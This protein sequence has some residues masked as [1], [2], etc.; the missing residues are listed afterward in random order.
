MT[1][2]TLTKPTGAWTYED[3][4][5]LPDDGRRFELIDGELH[6]LPAPDMDHQRVSRRI[7]I[8]IYPV[9]EVL[10]A[11]VL[12]APLDV[13]LLIE[14]G[15]VRRSVQ[16][17]LLVLLPEQR[18]P[19]GART[20]PVAGPPALVVEILSTSNP[21]HDTVRKRRWYAEAGV[22][23]YWIVDRDTRSIEVLVLEGNT[24]RT[25]LR[26]TGDALVTSTVLPGLAFSAAAV[27]G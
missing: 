3:L 8:V 13:A 14:G 21:E 26:A 12:Y 16:P 9:A 19:T 7:F 20:R 4:E 27:F 24:Y 15:R 1:V 10:D 6:E 25:H 2:S 5:A 22:R 18:P 17:D 23:E 11:E